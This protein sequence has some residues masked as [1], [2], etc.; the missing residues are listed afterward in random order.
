MFVHLISLV[1]LG[2]DAAYID[3]LLKELYVTFLVLLSFVRCAAFS[4]LNFRLGLIH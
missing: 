1:R 4:L 3:I 2:L